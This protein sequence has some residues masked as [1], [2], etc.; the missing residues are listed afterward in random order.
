MLRGR[1]HGGMEVGGAQCKGLHMLTCCGGG[2][3][4][5]EGGRGGGGKYTRLVCVPLRQFA[6]AG[7]QS[8]VAGLTDVC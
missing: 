4:L 7:F 1:V 2:C 8:G 6:R 5:R 3:M